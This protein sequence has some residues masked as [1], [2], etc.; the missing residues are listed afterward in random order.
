M[1]TSS[2][3]R[4]EYLREKALP[5]LEDKIAFLSRP[6]SYPEHTQRVETKQ[7]HMSWVFL[8]DT[9]AWKL[10]KP[11]RFNHLDLSSPEARRRNCQEEVR[12]NQRL[13][14]NVYRGVVPLTVGKGNALQLDKP[15]IIDDWLVCMR[16]LPS[17]RMLD[18]AIV[19]GTWTKEDL[20]K[21]GALLAD[22]YSSAPPIPLTSEYYLDQLRSE[23][24]SSRDELANLKYALSG[25]LIES[26]VNDGLKFLVQHRDLLNERVQ[27]GRIVEAHGD[28]RPEHICLEDEPVIIDCLEFNRNLRV[29]DP[30]S[31][32]MFL[33]LECDRLGAPE[34]GRLIL[35]IYCERTGDNPPRRLLEFYRTYHAC[36]R[37]KVAIW[38]LRDHDVRDRAKWT[39]RAHE[40]LQIAA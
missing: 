14:P 9:H 2:K 29:L 3:L 13:A 33:D 15:G 11:S 25:P 27:A 34:I 21:V 35:A 40:Y 1:I 18:Q 23:L 38:H 5:A 28:L 31:E 7:T 20:R 36:V 19:N 32:L 17:D 10:K 8:T 39:T 26:T 4:A 24:E 30:A 22:F 16:R 6:E 37:A 12:L